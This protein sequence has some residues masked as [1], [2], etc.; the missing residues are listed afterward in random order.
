MWCLLSFFGGRLISTNRKYSWKH[1]PRAEG[2]RKGGKGCQ[3]DSDVL[4]SR[5]ELAL[6][7]AFSQNVLQLLSPSSTAGS[8]CCAGSWPG[9]P[10]ESSAVCE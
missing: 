8:P 4:G 1:E 2:E 5:A 9:I 3:L 6:G 10:E 7:F